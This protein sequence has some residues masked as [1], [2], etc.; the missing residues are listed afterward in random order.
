MTFATSK[1]KHYISHKTQKWWCFTCEEE[2]ENS[3]ECWDKHYP[4]R[5]WHRFG[6]KLWEERREDYKD[7][8]RYHKGGRE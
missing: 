4:D 8:K 3:V 2:Y 6:R 1:P 7:L 5:L